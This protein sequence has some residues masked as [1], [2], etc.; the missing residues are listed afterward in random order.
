[1]TITNRSV[2]AFL[3][4]VTGAVLIAITFISIAE[5]PFAPRAAAQNAA[6]YRVDSN[7]AK[8]LYIT[9]FTTPQ[10]VIKVNLPD[11]MVAGDAVSGSI[12][13]EPTGKNETERRQNLEELNSYVIDLV[14]QQTAV[15][16]R[17]FTRNIN[18]TITIVLLHHGQ[19][20]ATA[21]IPILVTAPTRPTQ[22]TVPTGGQ[23]GRLLQI[24]RSCNGVVSSQD[25]VR[26]GGTQLPVIAESP[27]KLVVH[28]TSEVSG[29]TQMDLSEN[30]MAKQCPFRNIRPNYRRQN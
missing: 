5:T 17:T 2:S 27:R 6:G 3:A 21:T 16:D 23:Q 1:M 29:P 18:R 19:S 12:Y 15:R 8:L 10:G 30:G 24:D 22:F 28:N 7:P 4:R 14:G 20:V 26:I 9:T 25:Y 13:T 11:A